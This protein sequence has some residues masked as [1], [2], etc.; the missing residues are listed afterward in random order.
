MSQTVAKGT[1]EPVESA[2]TDGRRF[3][4]F[5]IGLIVA[6]LGAGAMAGTQAGRI[7]AGAPTPYVGLIERVSFHGP[8]VWIL[9][10]AI[11]LL[12]QE[13]ERLRRGGPSRGL[14]AV[15]VEA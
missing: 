5:S 14:G 3:R 12:R 10:L 13:R 6:I 9:A 1:L 7:A 11:D 4:L 2:P 15:A 8:G